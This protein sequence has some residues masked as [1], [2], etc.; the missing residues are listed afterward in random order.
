[1][2]PWR[3]NRVW[4]VKSVSCALCWSADESS[5]PLELV[6]INLYS[7]RRIEIGEKSKK[8]T[9]VTCAYTYYVLLYII[10]YDSCREP[11]ISGPF[12]RLHTYYYYVGENI[13]H[14]ITYYT[15]Y[16]YLYTV[17]HTD[18]SVRGSVQCA[19]HTFVGVCDTCP[20]GDRMNAM[21]RS[22]VNFSTRF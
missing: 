7:K 21:I 15:T 9:T 13:V 22:G 12:H 10:F 14:V 11:L 4:T 1:M 2:S 16:T 8:K 5:F 3:E 20:R 17:I 19:R 6:R 18:S